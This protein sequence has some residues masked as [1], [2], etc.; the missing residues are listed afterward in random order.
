MTEE[1]RALKYVD[2]QVRLGDNMVSS[3]VML[4]KCFCD[5]NIVTLLTMQAH[6]GNLRAALDHCSVKVLCCTVM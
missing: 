2:S 1:G 5:E 4:V 6:R 3:H